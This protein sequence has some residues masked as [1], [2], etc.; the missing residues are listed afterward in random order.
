MK[1]ARRGITLKRSITWLVLRNDGLQTS[2]SCLQRPFTDRVGLYTGR[3]I[4]VNNSPASIARELFNPSTDRK[5][6]SSDE[7]EMI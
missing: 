6:S 7:K 5:S 4:F 2:L 3:Y 1:L